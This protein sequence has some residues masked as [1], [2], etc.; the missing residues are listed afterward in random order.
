[1]QYYNIHV[2]NYGQDRTN[3][4]NRFTENNENLHVARKSQ[5]LENEKQ[6]SVHSHK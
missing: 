5:S 4:L 6:I 2:P 3:P 1:M